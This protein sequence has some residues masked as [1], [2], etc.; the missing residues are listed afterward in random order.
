MDGVFQEKNGIVAFEAENTV[1][2]EGWVLENKIEQYS[3]EGYITWVN[4]TSIET[5]GQGLLLYKFRITKPGT[6]TLKFRNYHACE[7]FTECNDVFVRIN[8]GEWRKNFNHTVNSWD[9]NSR[10]DIDHVF[11]DSEYLL[12]EGQ[13]ILYFSGRSQNFSIDKIALFHEDAFEGEYKTAEQSE[14]LAN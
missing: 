4:N 2:T 1:L 8:D 5:N 10:Q 7:D 11:S 9:W 13:H 3:G 14:C 12:E 6:Y